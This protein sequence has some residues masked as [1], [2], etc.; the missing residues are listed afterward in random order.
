MHEEEGGAVII[1]CLQ[2]HKSIILIILSD[3]CIRNIIIIVAE[4]GSLSART[5]MGIKIFVKRSFTIFATNA[6]FLGVI[7]NLH[8]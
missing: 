4:V 7:A 8:N 5:K 6:S 3:R 2:L 1:F